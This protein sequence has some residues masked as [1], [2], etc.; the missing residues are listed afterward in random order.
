[1]FPGLFCFFYI[2]VLLVALWAISRW[3]LGPFAEAARALHAPTRFFLSDFIWLLVLLQA[4]FA[5]ARL[6]LDQQGAFIA[7]LVFLLLASVAIWGGAVGVL[8][9]AG[10]NQ[11]LRRGIFVLV[12]LPAVLLLLAAIGVGIVAAVAWLASGP[13]SLGAAAAILPAGITAIVAV[14]WAL[15]QLTRWIAAGIPPPDTLDGGNEAIDGGQAN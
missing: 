1:M 5:A 13:D 7:I 12:L 15:R 2:P 10:I 14:A 6:V 9:R 11:A 4:S 8:S 3:V